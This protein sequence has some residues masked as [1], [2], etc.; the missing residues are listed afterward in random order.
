MNDK[1]VAESI[2]PNLEIRPKPQP[3]TSVEMVTMSLSK[4]GKEYKRKRDLYKALRYKAQVY[5]PAEFYCGYKFMQQILTREKKFFFND[6][7]YRCQVECLSEFS[8]KRL[9]DIV[10]DNADVMAYL[11]EVDLDNPRMMQREFLVN[12]MA[13]LDHTFFDRAVDE[14]KKNR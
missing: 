12:I 4:L 5:L 11:P 14:A 2:Y 1:N 6:G 9:L 3:D 8:I 10:K 13:T 7:V